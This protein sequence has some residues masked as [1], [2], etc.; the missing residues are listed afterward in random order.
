MEINLKALKIFVSYTCAENMDI[1]SRRIGNIVRILCVCG[2]Y[3]YR[4]VRFFFIVN[5]AYTCAE[6]MRPEKV[7]VPLYHC[8]LCVCG[9][10]AIVIWLL[11]H[12]TSYPIRVRKIWTTGCTDVPIEIISYM[13]AE[14]MF[15]THMK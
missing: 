11:I 9:K 7:W 2:K 14:N 5:V 10:Y 15:S 6:N 4:K 3:E 8:I 1:H 13:C 12:Q